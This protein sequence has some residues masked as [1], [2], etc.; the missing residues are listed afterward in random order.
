MSYI[1]FAWIS[2]EKHKTEHF[3]QIIALKIQLE[4]TVLKVFN[5]NLNLLLFKSSLVVEIVSL[6]TWEWLYT[7]HFIIISLFVLFCV[8]K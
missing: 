1:V 2:S 3:V 8:I 6:E 7:L 5:R 4:T